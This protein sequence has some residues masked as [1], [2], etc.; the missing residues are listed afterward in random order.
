MWSPL[1]GG[2][3][4]DQHAHT[5]LVD[6]SG[7]PIVTTGSDGIKVRPR[8]AGYW[9]SPSDSVA[10]TEE[11][12][13]LAAGTNTI[14]MDPVPAGY[15]YLLARAACRYLGTVTSVVMAINAIIDGQTCRLLRVDGIATGAWYP[16]IV[17]QLMAAGDYLQLVVTNATLNDDATINYSGSKI[18]IA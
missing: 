1:I 3:D 12:T 13:T 18:P 11:N 4:A 16:V 6:S 9:L 8:F 17:P 5:L 15:F 14:N 10:D 2:L 7:S